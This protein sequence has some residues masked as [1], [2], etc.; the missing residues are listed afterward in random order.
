MASA[1][2]FDEPFNVKE[3][4]ERLAWRSLG[5]GSRMDFNAG[6]LYK[7]LSAH[8]EQL[9]ILDQKLEKKATKLE[10]QLKEDAKKYADK[11]VKLKSQHNDAF[12]CFKELDEKI[13]MVA[14]KVVYLGEQLEA[15]NQPRAHAEEALNLMKHFSHFQEDNTEELHNL[16]GDP[17]NLAEA[18]E[19]IRKLK[20]IASELNDEKFKSVKENINRRYN[21][22]E[23]TLVGKFQEATN[24]KNKSEMK[25]YADILSTF[26]GYQKCI[27]EFVHA[28]L[29]QITRIKGDGIFD[30]IVEQSIKVN[31]LSS[32]V[33]THSEQVV[34]KFLQDVYE[35]KLMTYVDYKMAPHEF[36]DAFLN[37][38]FDL[39]NKV[40][41]MNKNLLDSK[42]K[43]KINETYLNKLEKLLFMDHVEDYIELEAESLKQSSHMS[44]EKFYEEIAHERKEDPNEEFE[45]GDYSTSFFGRKPDIGDGFEKLK[46][47]G[48]YTHRIMM[49]NFT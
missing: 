9:K 1:E 26:Q 46:S 21:D 6:L 10:T 19:I 42:C 13:N 27:N 22:I 40:K 18:A 39:K 37:E 41:N 5:G 35:D 48:V 38:V 3:Y 8:V 28:S 23:H 29:K 24:N 20:M 16:Y 25:K 4:I 12:S 15:T 34:Q 49:D 30:Q 7:E 45:Y 33:F 47:V 44:L 32:D 36:R 11:L 14:A 31:E 17:R 2:L 43:S